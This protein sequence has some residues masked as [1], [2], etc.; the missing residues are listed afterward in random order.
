MVSKLV[1]LPGQTRFARH[2]VTLALAGLAIYW[3]VTKAE[4]VD[5]H[6]I[7]ALVADI[8][9]SAWMAALLA[10]VA[11]FAAVGQYDV[12]FHRWLK[13]NV[14]DSRAARSGMASIALA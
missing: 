4:T 3:V 10:T 9:V 8:N 14:T 13:T 7:W 12:L 11:S 2:L 1:V 5:P 6:Q